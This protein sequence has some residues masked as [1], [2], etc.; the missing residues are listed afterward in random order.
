MVWGYVVIFF[1]IKNATVVI[2][3][4]IC[5]YIFNSI[6][7][8]CTI[9]ENK[10]EIQKLDLRKNVGT[11]ENPF[12]K[13]LNGKMFVRPKINTVIAKGQQIIN[14]ESQEVLEDRVVMGKRI[15]VDKSQFAKIYVTEIA[16][17]IN[18]SKKASFCLDVFTKRILNF[19]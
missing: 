12:Y 6:K 15:F 11:L 14:K 13:E 16:D 19:L 2:F 8:N 5:S 4:Y 9:M 17:L 10:T 18:L 7:Y 3:D 1:L